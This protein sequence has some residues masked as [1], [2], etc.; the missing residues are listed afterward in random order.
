[1]TE[2]YIFMMMVDLY[3]DGINYNIIGYINSWIY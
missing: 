2:D 1:M 3:D